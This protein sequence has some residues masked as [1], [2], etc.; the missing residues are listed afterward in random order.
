VLIST[1]HIL[2]FIRW[3]L[4]PTQT[5]CMPQNCEIVV[6]FV[7]LKN[8]INL[9]FV[10]ISLCTYTCT[11]RSTFYSI[12][13]GYCGAVPAKVKVMQPFSENIGFRQE[14]LHKSTYNPTV[15]DTTTLNT[16]S[17]PAK[18]TFPRTLKLGTRMTEGYITSTMKPKRQPG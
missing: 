2:Y 3:S 11:T 15:T 7:K 4:T 1:R 18:W 14:H 13:T 8:D 10:D 9:L 6:E 5:Q 17:E 16:V 12:R